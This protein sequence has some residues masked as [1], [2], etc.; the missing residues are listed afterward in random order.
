M[1]IRTVH[2]THDAW[3]VLFRVILRL[4]VP[5]PH[6][7]DGFF[8]EVPFGA[9]GIFKGGYHGLISFTFFNVVFL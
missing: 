4:P 6:A 1:C 5:Q 8:T 9:L 2:N 7:L 3:A